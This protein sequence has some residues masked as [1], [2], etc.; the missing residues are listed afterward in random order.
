MLSESPF[1]GATRPK[2]PAES[3]T[4]GLSPVEMRRLR[5]SEALATDVPDLGWDRGH[6]TRQIIRKGGPITREPLV[7]PMA[8]A[9]D[10]YLDGRTDGPTSS[11]PAA[12]G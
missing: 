1:L 10:D 5:I 8:R 11:P 6:H 2:P 4:V 12:A 3:T 7:P 9:I